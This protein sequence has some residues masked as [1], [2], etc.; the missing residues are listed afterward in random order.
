MELDEMT[1]NINMRKI[2]KQLSLTFTDEVDVGEIGYK[3]LSDGLHEIEETFVWEDVMSVDDFDWQPSVLIE[4]RR[5]Y[6]RTC[7]TEQ[8]ITECG[9]S[10]D[11]LGEYIEYNLDD[12]IE[13]NDSHTQ[14]RVYGGFR[15][16]LNKQGTETIRAFLQGHIDRNNERQDWGLSK[17]RNDGNNVLQ[18]PT[19]I[20]R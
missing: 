16:I 7:V 11:S 9:F 4:L 15:P 14:Y 12:W 5:E 3:H 17:V 8:E 6:G 2:R 18:F 13:N 10:L 20:N 1:F 19:D